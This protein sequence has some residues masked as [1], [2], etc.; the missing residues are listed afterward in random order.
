MISFIK[1]LGIVT[2]GLVGEL[3]TR[4]FGEIKDGK[5]LLSPEEVLYLME[6]RKRINVE[7]EKGKELGFKEILSAASRS[8]KMFP[9]KYLVYKDLRDRGYIVKTGFKFG[10]HYRVYP[11][12]VKPGEGHAAWLIHVIKENK[13]IEFPEISRSV[14][15]ANNVRKK[16]IF[17]VVDKE[18]DIT[19]YLIDR[20]TP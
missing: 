12:G 2:G 18:G 8:D 5:L 6:K 15:L 13:K 3:N 9:I 20:F 14:R 16:M 10:A 4:G 1:G 19:Y 7:D 17:A 11:R